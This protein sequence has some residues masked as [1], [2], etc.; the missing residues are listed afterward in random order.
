MRLLDVPHH[1]RLCIPVQIPLS[2]Q[3]VHSV[4]RE[5]PMNR[6]ISSAI[7]VAAALFLS[8]CAE[9]PLSDEKEA[10]S[11]REYVTGSNLPKKDRSSVRVVN[12]GDFENAQ[13]GGSIT[14]TSK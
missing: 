12:P 6:A 7:L 11:E 2:F 3:A 10:K 5:L 9:L 4:L 13:R 1:A 8:S 14:P